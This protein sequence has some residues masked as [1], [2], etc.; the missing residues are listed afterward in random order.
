MILLVED[1]TISR[2]AFT[3]ILRAHGH[4]VL[5]AADGIEAL[6]LLDK[7][8]IDLV[9]TDL[10]LPNLSG[11]LL[12]THI[13]NRWPKMPAILISA[14]LSEDAG[15]IILDGSADFLPKPIDPPAL[16]ATIQRLLP[17]A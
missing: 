11:L 5:E 10:A 14:Y 15:K 4:E 1:D 12:V 7:W 8:T 9:I 6:A 16:L 2:T 3:K 17:Q 13:R